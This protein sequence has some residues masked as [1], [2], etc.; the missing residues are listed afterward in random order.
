MTLTL[1]RGGLSATSGGCM[2]IERL[3][4]SHVTHRAAGEA[5]LRYGFSGKRS[6]C[7]VEIAGYLVSPARDS[8]SRRDELRA[9]RRTLARITAPGDFVLRVDAVRANL[10]CA[11]LD[12]ER[13]APFSGDTAERFRIRAAM[14]GGYFSG[15]EITLTSVREPSGGATLPG[16]I[17]SG[18]AV[19]S[20][21]TRERIILDNAGDV[22]APFTAQLYPTC[23][24]EGAAI[25]DRNHGRM[26]VCVYD[27]VAGDK[28]IVNTAPESAG[29]TLLRGSNK[30]DLAGTFSPSTKLFSLATGESD[31]AFY[32]RDV[33]IP[34]T[35]TYSPLY[36]SI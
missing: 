21:S 32:Y 20:L 5:E 26:L 17:T 7:Y 35:L 19:A 9:W 15:D 16:A 28:I 18:T 10:T 34:A 1:E 29:A 24:V 11:E 3:E 25:V 13:S 33:P 31:L 4:T 8:G 2:V 27:F 6:T 23:S 30:I 14:R 22:P 12:F 36:T